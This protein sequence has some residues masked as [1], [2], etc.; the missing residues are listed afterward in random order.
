MLCNSIYW[1]MDVVVVVCPFR[2]PQVNL[3]TTLGTTL[4]TTTEFHSWEL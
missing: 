2:A 4:E 1:G 3:V